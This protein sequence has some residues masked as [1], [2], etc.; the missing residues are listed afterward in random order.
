MKTYPLWLFWLLAL[1]FIWGFFLVTVGF[2]KISGVNEWF[3]LFVYPAI[4]W[5]AAAFLLRSKR[6][7]RVLF[8]A[9]NALTGISWIVLVLWAAREFGRHFWK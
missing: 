9:V 5:P 1:A 4:C 7:G 2:K 3:G 6:N 8:S